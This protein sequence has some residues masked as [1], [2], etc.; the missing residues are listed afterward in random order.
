MH[1]SSRTHLEPW[2]GEKFGPVRKIIG[3]SE[4][5]SERASEWSERA[6]RNRF[7][8]RANVESRTA[9]AAERRESVKTHTSVVWP[10]IHYRWPQQRA[11]LEKL[12]GHF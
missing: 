6:T 10:Q 8:R 12:G 11:D 5:A 9:E 4:I 7:V 1:P 2:R 3:Y